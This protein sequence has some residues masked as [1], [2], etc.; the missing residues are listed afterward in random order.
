MSSNV[1]HLFV[2]SKHAYG[3]VGQDLQAATGDSV[4]MVAERFPWS[5]G[6]V[7]LTLSLWIVHKDKVNQTQYNI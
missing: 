4:R 2:H 6:P 3:V 7:H 5:G 1:A